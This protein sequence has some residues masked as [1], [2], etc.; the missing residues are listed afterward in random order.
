VTEYFNK[1]KPTEL[2]RAGKCWSIS[3]PI[4][5]RQYALRTLHY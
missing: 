3:G 2:S 5:S 4:T 1:C